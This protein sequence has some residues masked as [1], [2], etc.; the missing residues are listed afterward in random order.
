MASENIEFQM[1]PLFLK[2][3]ILQ[4]NIQIQKFIPLNQG[5]VCSNVEEEEE[6]GIRYCWGELR[7]T[8]QR[9]LKHFQHEERNTNER[10][11]NEVGSGEAKLQIESIFHILSHTYL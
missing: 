8:L 7:Q 5:D 3:F 11:K 9:K 10:I 4:G 6:E 1:S 2:V